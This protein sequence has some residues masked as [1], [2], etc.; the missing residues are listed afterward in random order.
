MGITNGKINKTLKTRFSNKHSSCIIIIIIANQIFVCHN[1]YMW[2]FW[3]YLP[4]LYTWVFNVVYFYFILFCLFFIFFIIST[5]IS[6][7]T[8]GVIQWHHGTLTHPHKRSLSILF[9]AFNSISGH[10]LWFAVWGGVCGSWARHRLG[11]TC[12][13]H[14][15]AAGL[16]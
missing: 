11:W 5:C 2:I 1:L 4:K 14:P 10:V 7:T 13:T 16:I 3:L 8:F 12:T 15:S 6:W 9:V